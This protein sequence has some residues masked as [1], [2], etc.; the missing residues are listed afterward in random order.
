M[1]FASILPLF[2]KLKYFTRFIVVIYAILL[3][4][5]SMSISI[6]EK[7]PSYFFM[8]GASV[9]MTGADKD[10]SDNMDILIEAKENGTRDWGAFFEVVGGI[11]L[12]YYFIKLFYWLFDKSFEMASPL[13]KFI[14]SALII[15]LI[16]TIFLTA[17]HGY[18]YIGFQGIVKFLLNLDAFFYPIADWITAVGE[19]SIKS[20][21]F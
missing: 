8:H 5:S 12:F 6:R 10:I 20:P 7:D 1:S 16:Q 2:G 9:I 11:L 13:S 21:L 15:F 19:F 18:L 14:F 17:T 4:F 3:L